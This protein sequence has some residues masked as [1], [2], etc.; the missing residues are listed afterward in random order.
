M[1]ASPRVAIIIPALNE[2]NQIGKV[3]EAATATTLVDEVLVV[4]D[5][6]KDKTAAVASG[7]GA[8]VIRSEENG[9]K[10]AA[11]QK[12]AADT[13]AEI[14]VFIDADLV[15]LTVKHIEDMVRPL[16]DDEELEM[17]VGRFHGG[18][19]RTDLAQ[20]IVPFISGQRAMRRSFLLSLPDLAATR[21]GVEVVITRCAKENG[22]N[23]KEVMLPDLTQVMKE[24]KLGFVKGFWAR[25]VMYADMVR[26]SFSPKDRHSDH[27]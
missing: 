19:L 3:L 18:R 26:H 12:G 15:G 1:T 4:D 27:A 2:E 23:V 25:L 5:G 7:R 17:T 20:L 6:S 9:G 11:M 8:R 10:G 13:D 21:F 14:L 16:L 22:T 24:E